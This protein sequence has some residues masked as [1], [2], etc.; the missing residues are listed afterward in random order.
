MLVPLL[1]ALAI[2]AVV[3]VVAVGIVGVVRG[4]GPGPAGAVGQ[5]T[6]VVETGDVVVKVTP[7]A[8]GPDQV[9]FAVTMETH[10]GSIDVDLPAA[11]SLL[12]DGTDAGPGTWTGPG[13]GGHHLD[14]TLSF[15]ATPSDD[16]V[17]ELRITGLAKPI[18]LAWPVAGSSS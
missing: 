9:A 8:T 13:P 2:V 5:Q 10:A 16:S 17:L 7:Q 1:L 15:A 6:R 18:E 4:N 12:V 11:A 14:G 3:A